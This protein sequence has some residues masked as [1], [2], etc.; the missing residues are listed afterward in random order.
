[1]WRGDAEAGAV[2]IGDFEGGSYGGYRFAGCEGRLN[3]IDNVVAL[4][5]AEDGVDTIG[6]DEEVFIHSL[7]QAAG[8]DDLLHFAF[9]FLADGEVYCVERFGFGGCD[10]ATGIDDDDVC[11]VGILCDDEAGLG[12]EGEHP[13]AVHHIFGTAE[14]DEADGSPFF[15]LFNIH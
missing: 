5:E 4:L 10:E 13:F 11:V 3:Y 2:V 1:V 7:C 8:D 6:F 14:G 12:D 9:L 15:I